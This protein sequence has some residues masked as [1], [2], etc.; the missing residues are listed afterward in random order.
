MKTFDEALFKKY[1]EFLTEIA[2]TDMTKSMRSYLKSKD[3]LIKNNL[4]EEFLK[5]VERRLEAG[6]EL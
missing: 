2:N 6:E 5:E 3:W 4:G 1:G